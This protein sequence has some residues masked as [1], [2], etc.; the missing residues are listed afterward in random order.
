MI[1]CNRVA[2]IN[3]L[4]T[5]GLIILM[6]NCCF[7][8][9]N[10]H[11]NKYDPNNI[12]TSTQYLIDHNINL[13]R[14]EKEIMQLSKE[15]SNLKSQTSIGF[16]YSINNDILKLTKN[17]NT[18]SLGDFREVIDSIIINNIGELPE[19]ADE[20]TNLNKV[21]T[22]YA[23][24]ALLSNVVK[25]NINTKEHNLL[26]LND[27]ENNI[28]GNKYNNGK[29]NL[30]IIKYKNKT[31]AFNTKLKDNTYYYTVNLK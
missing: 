15:L 28:F 12:Y 1:L 13:I 17:N 21:L 18:I 3:I 6:N 27:K 10:N 30:G 19:E 29:E 16:K 24:N 14:K 4:K 26:L 20:V 23:I 22:E 31:C 5:V 8:I 11:N 2:L 7:A 25:N 9:T